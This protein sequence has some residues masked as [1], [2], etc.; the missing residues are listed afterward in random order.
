[1]SSID[2]PNSRFNR[3]YRPKSSQPH[4]FQQIVCPTL[5]QCNCNRPTHQQ[6]NVLTVEQQSTECM[7]ARKCF[8]KYNATCNTR[9]TKMGQC[10]CRGT[11]DPSTN[12]RKPTET[13]N[14]TATE[15]Q[16][17]ANHQTIA[18]QCA[19]HNWPNHKRK[20]RPITGHVAAIMS[21]HVLHA[22]ANAIATGG[23]NTTKH[24]PMRAI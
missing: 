14:K 15:N 22:K 17:M 19:K 2:A 16:T 11:C 5:P 9:N 10:A 12:L 13:L 7:Y 24:N 21:L 20:Q 8:A 18:R 1:M 4:G 3:K 23:A 6:C